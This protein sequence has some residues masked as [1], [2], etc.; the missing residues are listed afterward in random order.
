MARNRHEKINF[1]SPLLCSREQTET[2]KYKYFLFEM[3]FWCNN[4]TF[5]VMSAPSRTI[6]NHYNCSDK[7]VI[8]GTTHQSRPG[9][10][11]LQAAHVNLQL[12]KLGV[13]A[14]TGSIKK[15]A[16]KQKQKQTKNQPHVVVQ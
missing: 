14:R 11:L 7:C 12:L 13:D 8:E 5:L 16:K 3:K 1:L 9:V 6:F 2:K 15:P 4:G 10:R